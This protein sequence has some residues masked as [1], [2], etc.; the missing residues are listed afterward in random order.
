MDE[1]EEV[2]ENE[3]DVE[4]PYLVTS[5]LS[6]LN[7]KSSLSNIHSAVLGFFLRRLLFYA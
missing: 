3:E 7:Q 6:K 5:L 1:D 4:K 2:E